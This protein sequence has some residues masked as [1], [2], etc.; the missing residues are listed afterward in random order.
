MEASSLTHGPDPGAIY[1]MPGQQR[2]VFLKNIINDPRIEV[3]EYTYYDDFADPHHFLENVLYHFP[4]SQD[5][6]RIG[7]FCMIASGAKFVMNGGNHRTDVFTAYPF[8]IFGQGWE[9]AFGP[10]K[11][12][13]KGD[14]VVGHDVWIGHDAL[15]M[16]GVQVGNG[17]IIATRAVVARDVPPYAVVA[18]NPA[19]VVRMRFDADTI[20][21]L[22]QV[23]WWNWDVAKITRNLAAICSRDLAALER[24]E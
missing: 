16:P 13:S 9:Q 4:F 6:L 7:R 21:R 1:P 2:L 22:E 24:A 5:K 3:G 15:L 19:T 17:A 20:A 18:G 12:P 14:L 11:W 10:D 23:A 8:P